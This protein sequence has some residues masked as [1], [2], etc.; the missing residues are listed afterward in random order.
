[1]LPMR[2]DTASLLRYS[3]LRNNAQ[4]CSSGKSL[5]TRALVPARLL[6]HVFELRMPLDFYEVLHLPWDRV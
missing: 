6:E 5:R 4:N 2:M 3:Q 1:M